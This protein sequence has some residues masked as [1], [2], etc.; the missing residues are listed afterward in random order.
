MITL[1]INNSY[2]QILNLTTDQFKLL[3]KDLSYTVNSTGSY[4]AKQFQHKKYLIS[5]RGDFPTGLLYIVMRFI[6]INNLKTTIIDNRIAPKP[7]INAPKLKLTLT[8]YPEQIDAA[9]A[10][11][12]RSR[13]I[14][15]CVTGFGKSLVIALTIDLLKV[16]T[17]IIVPS[18]H[19]KHQ[20]SESLKE[21]FGK[22][23]V[24]KNKF[25]QVENI[26]SKELNAKS[27]ANLL[28][29][30]E[31]HHSA[32][33]T[34]RDL[35][36]K[37][38]ADIYYRVGLTATPYR[39]QDEERLLLESILSEII[40]TVDY[41]MAVEKGYIVPI[42]AYYINLP[43]SKVNGHTWHQVYSEIV[44]KNDLRNEIIVNL[45][46]SAK[47]QGI[48]TL[49]LVKEIA[50]GNRISE[51]A[52]LPFASGI[53]E[54][55]KELIYDFNEKIIPILVGTSGVLG[56]GVDTRPAELII[57]AGLGKSKNQFLQQL[58][59]G[60]RKYNGK[61]SCKII[62]FNDNAHKWTKSHFKEQVKYLLE[63]GITPVELKL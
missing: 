10:V 42:E 25:I 1:K 61:E 4:Y 57:I 19:L 15:S 31:F 12:T 63:L 8:P 7:F 27:N 40:Y 9:R 35:N 45:L 54:N 28:I 56:E 18:L 22:S 41:K 24:G 30:D 11:L 51:L 13:G 60:V 6:T 47:E 21:W 48:S 37:Q 55:T 16:P 3:R 59:R 52:G 39:S 17:L 38:W 43:T 53:N 34:Y 5:T 50:H 14:L 44:V 46:T 33:K 58:G 23:F 62:I 26:D 2:S 36:K 32:A 49:C 29:L 20:L